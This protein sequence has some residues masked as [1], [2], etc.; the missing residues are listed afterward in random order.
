MAELEPLLINL[1]SLMC[2]LHKHL[3]VTTPVT[4]KS[5]PKLIGMIRAHNEEK[6][7]GEIETGVM[8]EEYLQD[9]VAL[10][11]DL[12]P[13]PLVSLKKDQAG[14]E[15]GEK[16]W[17]DLE[18]QFNE[19]KSKQE[20]ELNELKEKLSK[21]KEKCDKGASD[22]A[23]LQ[24]GK[25]EVAAEITETSLGIKTEK[26]ELKCDF[27]ISGQFGEA[28]QQDKLTYVALIHQIDLGLTKGYKESSC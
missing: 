11:T 26:F 20:S 16:E 10:L 18:K 15:K 19:L 17:K 9:Q 28:G 23:E 21:A 3:K 14:I 27:K 7:E 8:P 5:K 2:E 25:D 1:D 24:S 22:S 4:G 12:I 6:L 13:P